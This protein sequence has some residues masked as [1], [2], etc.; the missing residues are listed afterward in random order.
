MKTYSE[1][2][3]PSPRICILLATYNG[4]SW[5]DEQLASIARQSDVSV[6]VV[7]SDDASSDATV[8]KLNLW[9]Q[10]M[11]LA[12]L[13]ANAGRFGN[14]CRNFLRL[15]K[16]V[17]IGDSEYVALA[18]QDDLWLPDKLKRSVDCLNSGNFDVYS[19]DVEAFWPDGRVAVLLKSRPQSNFDYLFESAGP[20]CT[21]VFRRRFFQALRTWVI[22]HYSS[23]QDI[24]VHDWLIYAYARKN[25]WRWMIDDQINMR[26]R[27][28]GKNEIGAN[29]GWRA[30]RVRLQAARDGVF[31]RDVLGLA[32][33]IAETAW[34]ICA[35]EHLDLRSRLRLMLSV[36]SF[37]R[38]TRDQFVLAILFLLMRRR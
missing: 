15:I 27:Q 5:L 30:A 1:S 25:G 9:S 23:L 35:L 12:I 26:Y 3:V 31:R 37:R 19:A 6:S 16:D 38:R 8:T 10:Q 33:V 4:A 28:H 18:D 29:V 20:G 22:A 7:V 11:P 21:Y 36:D 17:D 34:P 2:A 24:K 32:D 13:P 14:A